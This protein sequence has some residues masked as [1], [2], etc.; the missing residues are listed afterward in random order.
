MLTSNLQKTDKIER[1]ILF[2]SYKYSQT[3]G[4]IWL[5]MMSIFQDVKNVYHNTA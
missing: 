2:Q 5:Q 1:L 4:N 3:Q